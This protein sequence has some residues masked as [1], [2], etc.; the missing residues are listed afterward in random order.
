MADLG[1]PV[2]V[3]EVVPITDPVPTIPGPELEPAESP[4]APVEV[5]AEV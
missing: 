3:I 2:R 4:A 5:P 1:N